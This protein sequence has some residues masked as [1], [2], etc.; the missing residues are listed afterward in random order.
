M[1]CRSRAV[2][3]RTCVPRNRLNRYL[4]NRY[5]DPSTDQFLA[6]DPLVGETGQAFSYANN[7][8]VNGSDP[9]GL[10]TCPSWLLG[11]GVVTNAQNTINGAA[12][13]AGSFLNNESQ[14]LLC[15][16]VGGGNSIFNGPLGCAN[17]ANGPACS[18]SGATAGALNPG[19]TEEDVRAALAE[20]GVSVPSDYRAERTRNGK[21]WVFRPPGSTNDDNAIETQEAGASLKSPNGSYRIYNSKGVPVD[22]FGRQ[23]GDAGIGQAETHFEFPPDPIP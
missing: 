7:D 14:T 1:Y 3:G 13:A 2:K 20:Q 11:C 5:Y 6:V 21:G 18:T 12:N 15:N 8:P 19:S 4:V 10:I 23:L 22:E 17:D 9:S 16:A